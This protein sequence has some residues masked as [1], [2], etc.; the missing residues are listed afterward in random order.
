[1]I[2]KIFL[3][4]SEGGRGSAKTC[5]MWG[6]GALND[7][8]QVKDSTTIAIKMEVKSGV[9]DYQMGSRAAASI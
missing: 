7:R 4:L 5:V 3:C 2:L 6:L 1:M 8:D 9:K